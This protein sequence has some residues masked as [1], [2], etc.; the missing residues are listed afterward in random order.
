[1]TTPKYHTEKLLVHFRVYADGKL[2]RQYTD[3]RTVYTTKSGRKQINELNSRV[4]LLEEGDKL[5]REINY[6][7]IPGFA[8]VPP[9]PVR[10]PT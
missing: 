3:T 10:R 1:M 5:V 6:R 4:D 7:T 9:F 2:T 8:G